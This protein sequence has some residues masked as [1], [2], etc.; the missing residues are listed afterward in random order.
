MYQERVDR[1]AVS[2]FPVWDV[3]PAHAQKAGPAWVPRHRGEIEPPGREEMSGRA[4]RV[5]ISRESRT[6]HQ[7]AR[8]ELLFIFLDLTILC[9][10]KAQLDG[11]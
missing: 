7:Q 2:A 8:S 6:R 11:L 10:E 3:G 1:A 4:L 5:Q 9:N